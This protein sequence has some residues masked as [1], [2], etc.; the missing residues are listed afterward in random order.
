MA[1]DLLWSI[2]IIG[3]FLNSA[4]QKTHGLGVGREKKM[5]LKNDDSSLVPPRAASSS[6]VWRV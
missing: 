1:I 2:F 4:K 5:I 6:V 3:G